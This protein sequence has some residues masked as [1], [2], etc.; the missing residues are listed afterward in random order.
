VR[1]RHDYHYYTGD[2]DINIHLEHV[3]EQHNHSWLDIHHDTTTNDFVINVERSGYI[4]VYVGGVKHKLV[5]DVERIRTDHNFDSVVDIPT[6]DGVV[7]TTP[8]A[9]WAIDKLRAVGG[10]DCSLGDDPGTTTG[11]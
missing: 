9:K 10:I 1:S 5:P 3:D 2:N 11:D 7:G 8:F 6:L 4:V